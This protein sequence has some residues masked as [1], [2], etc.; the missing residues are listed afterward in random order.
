VGA[1]PAQIDAA[2]AELPITRTIKLYNSG[3]FFDPRAIPPADHPA[4]AARLSDFDRVI[5]ENHPRLVTP[6]VR[7]FADRLPGR[8]EVAMGLETV[9]PEILPRLN[10]RM[11]VDDFQRAAGWLRSHEIDVRAFL[12]VGLPGLDAAACRPWGLE[13]LK[14]AFAAGAQCCSLILTRR[15]NGAMDRLH[16]QGDFRP[17]SLSDL[18]WLQA[19]G[20][21]LA[22]GRVFADAWG[23]EQLWSCPHCG[24]RQRDCLQTMNLTQ[25]I[26][27]WPVCECRN[28]P[29]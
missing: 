22:A 3:N 18:Y 21:A 7:A 23:L 13:S 5:V 24:P 29:T 8:L 28:S 9:H 14:T 17:A 2:L 11:T 10:K 1:I 15:G 27:P 19:A 6:A 12:L 4:M 25:T 16:E 20:I 26:L